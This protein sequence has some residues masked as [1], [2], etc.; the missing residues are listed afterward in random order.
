MSAN[1]ISKMDDKQLRNEVQ[2]L[3]DELAIFKR[4]YEDIIYNLDD[5]NF[6]GKFLKEKDNMKTEIKVAAE[7]IK[8]KVSKDDL[9]KTLSEYSTISQTASQISATVT[10]AYVTNLI[11][12]EYVSDNVLKSQLDIQADGIYTTVSNTYQTK[13]D[14][15][16]AYGSLSGSIS[17]VSQ[18]ANSISTRVGKVENGQFGKYTL[19]EQTADGFELTGDVTVNGSAVVGGTITGASLQNSTGTTKITLGHYTGSTVGDMLLNRIDSAGNEQ[20]I[21][22]VIDNFQS[23]YLC[24]MGTAILQSSGATTYP[25]GTWN[26]EGCTVEGIEGGSGSGGTAIAVFG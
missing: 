18:T 14:A 13:A 17:S 6:S 12:N 11:G 23:I 19:F 10:K 2:L 25:K 21:F 8:T 15:N 4:K 16:S 5:D 9:D 24:A 1:D 7:G 22:S 3:R 26:F 20:T